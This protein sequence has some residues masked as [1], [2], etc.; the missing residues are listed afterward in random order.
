MRALL[1][2]FGWSVQSHH[3]VPRSEE[4]ALSLCRDALGGRCDRRHN[5]AVMAVTKMCFL[6]PDA[7]ARTRDAMVDRGGQF[8]RNPSVMDVAKID[9]FYANEEW[10][11]P[12]GGRRV[13]AEAPVRAVQIARRQRLSPGPH[14]QLR[15]RGDAR[16]RDGRLR[17]ELAPP[18]GPPCPRRGRWRTRSRSEL[19]DGNCL[20]KKASQAGVGQEQRGNGL[21]P[22]CYPT[23]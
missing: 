1:C 3:G 6:L 13:R 10:A 19:P 16:G 8:H 5:V 18:I 21:L 4:F 9:L 17:Y 7:P 14:A 12:A 11:K 22:F 15:L 2:Q 23:R 20:A